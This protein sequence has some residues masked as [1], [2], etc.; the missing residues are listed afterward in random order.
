MFLKK[1]LIW[2]KNSKYV[3]TNMMKEV[4]FRIIDRY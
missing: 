1:D 4:M 2:S 3:I